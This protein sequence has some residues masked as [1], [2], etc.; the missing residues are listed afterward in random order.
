MS[1]YDEGAAEANK[2][3]AYWALMA[4]EAFGNQTGQHEYLDGTLTIAPEV[5][6]EVAGDLLGNIFHLA[7]MNDLEPE[8]IIASAEMHF[9]EEVREEVEEAIEDTAQEV[10]AEAATE[11]AISEG[12]SKLEDFLKGQSK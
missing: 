7:R 11:I 10:I 2:T 8:S 12:I 3:R 9:E 1:I 4:L 6:R 5:I